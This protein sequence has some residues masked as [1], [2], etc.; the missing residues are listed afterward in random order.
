MRI[1]LITARFPEPG[2]RGD[3]LRARQQAELLHGEHDLVVLTGGTASS[4]TARAE[5]EALATVI[6]VPLSRRE[7]LFGA[8]AGLLRG[9][10]LQVSWMTP[11]RLRRLSAALAAPSDVVIASTIRCL[12]AP[13]PAPTLLDHIDSLSLN[14]RQRARLERRWPLRLAAALEARLLARHERHAASWSCAQAVVSPIDGRALPPQPVPVVMPLVQELTATADGTTE[15]DIDVILTGNM[16][17]PPNRDAAEW[18]TGE[19]VPLL[20]ERRPAVRVLVAGRSASVLTLAGVEVL[21]DVPD[22]SALLARAR[23]AIVPLRSGTGMPTKLLEAAAAG[24]AVVA[25]PWVGEAIGDPE[26]PTAFDAPG[27]AVAIERLLA[28]D[29]R[30]AAAVARGRALLA[31][32]SSE[33][34]GRTLGALLADCTRV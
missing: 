18:L 25:T 20:R 5:L 33:A 6:V 22:L 19:I 14:M 11:P 29:A 9:V 28:D 32:Y 1:L 8:L 17:Y 27:F 15:R 10:P 30:R 16:A 3:Q 21:G 24:A 13:L 4:A 7:R 26:L 23:V 12:P 2:F 34:I 31:H